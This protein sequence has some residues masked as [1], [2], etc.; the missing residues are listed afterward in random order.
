MSD[1]K[2]W[3][4]QDKCGPFVQTGF[5][6]EQYL[7][8]KTCKEEVSCALKDRREASKRQQWRKEAAAE[9]QDADVENLFS[10]ID[11]DTP[12]WGL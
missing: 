3:C 10:S 9:Y 8:C 2:Q 7:V 12:Y 4:Y 5:H 1:P 6:L 11:D